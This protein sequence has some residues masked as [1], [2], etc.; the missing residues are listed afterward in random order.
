MARE[1][2]WS[3]FERSSTS[4]AAPSS[5]S[6]SR[7]SCKAHARKAMA[8]LKTSSAGHRSR[9]RWTSRKGWGG[10]RCRHGSIRRECAGLGRG[11]IRLIVHGHVHAT[12]RRRGNAPGSGCDHPRRF[13]R[14]ENGH[15]VFGRRGRLHVRPISRAHAVAVRFFG[16]LVQVAGVVTLAQLFALVAPGL[17]HSLS[18]LHG[19]AGLDLSGPAL[20]VLV[21][22]HIEVGLTR[23]GVHCTAAAWTI[24]PFCGSSSSLRS[25]SWP[26]SSSSCFAAENRA[27]SSS[28]TWG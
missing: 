17:V 15:R 27:S 10:P 25:P 12:E 13:G 21:G 14:R 20:Q 26:A 2:R 23:A 24:S 11:W 16:G 6:L 3:A 9:F 8:T 19:R 1:L 4:A 7:R 28:R 5:P 22:S 18:T